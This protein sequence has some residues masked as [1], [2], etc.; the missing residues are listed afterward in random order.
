MKRTRVSE[1]LKSADFNR[2]VTVMGWVRTKRDGKNVAFIAVNDGSVI[3][4]IQAVVDVNNFDADLFKSISTGACVS[5]TGTLV[6][7]QGK[8]Q[9]SEIQAKKIEV[10]GTA[11]DSFPLECVPVAKV[12]EIAHWLTGQPQVIDELRLVFWQ[13]LTDS[14]QL[15][16][17]TAKHGQI[18]NVTFL[19]FAPFVEASQLP[20][21][22]KRDHTKFEFYLHALLINGFEK[23]AALIFVNLEARPSKGVAF[24]L[25]N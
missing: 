2:E 25:I 4:N 16:D 21:R 22:L 18:G 8:G 5:V 14:L 17:E 23:P 3:H 1:L 11:D 20:F 10:F 24:L 12:Y 9:S 6:Q 15:D 7:S 19:E 13:K